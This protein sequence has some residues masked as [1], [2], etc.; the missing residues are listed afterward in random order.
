MPVN[1]FN[2]QLFY[3]LYAAQIS[4]CL[5]A[6][7]SLRL[8]EKHNNETTLSA[9]EL[10]TL[11]EIDPVAARSFFNVLV[12]I[13]ILT[14]DAASYSVSANARAL[15]STKTDLT[16][17]PYLSIGLEGDAAN[18]EFVSFLREPSK[19]DRL[20]A[21]GGETSLM[22]QPNGI[23]TE[24]AYGLA[25]RARR[26][27]HLLAMSISNR[28][29]ENASVIDIGAGSPHL[30]IALS[31]FRPRWRITLA[32]RQNALRFIREMAKTEE[33]ILQEDSSNLNDG[34]IGLLDCN[35]FSRETLP[36][37]STMDAVIF[38]NV[39]HDWAP[40]QISQIV[41]NAL[42]CLKPGG[43]LV[44]HES[45]LS[46]DPADSNALCFAAYGMTLNQLTA[47]QGSCYFVKEY[48]DI[49]ARLGLKR[50]E[51][52]VITVDGCQALFYQV[53]Q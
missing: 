31:S 2:Q 6:A 9:K 7:L 21:E 13:G 44:V 26:F 16:M 5:R 33:I 27:A 24:V 20:Y 40:D 37:T 48:D 39:L 19:A 52:P 25:S 32:D 46:P 35:M 14:R 11:L 53:G 17:A 43:Y 36:R 51:E 49:L 38:S 30:A 18:A 10:A 47:G 34:Q 1:S 42:R 8:V 41:G 28:V 23:S 4:A 15:L 3:A 22:D 29:G 12:A 50:S 45:F